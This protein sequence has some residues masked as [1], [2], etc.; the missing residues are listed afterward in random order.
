MSTESKTIRYL[1]IGVLKPKNISFV[2]FDLFG[3]H[4]KGLTIWKQNSVRFH[5]L[6]IF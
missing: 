3:K 4:S 6:N 2:E 5:V 1:I